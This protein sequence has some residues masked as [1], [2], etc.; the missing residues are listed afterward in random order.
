MPTKNRRDNTAVRETSEVHVYKYTGIQEY[1]LGEHGVKQ[2]DRG[3]CPT[4]K[5]T[6][7]GWQW[8]GTGAGPYLGRALMSAA[9][10]SSEAVKAVSP[11]WLMQ[12]S[13]AK[14]RLGASQVLA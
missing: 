7:T 5:K 8:A 9:T 12:T 1:M 3:S 2:G 6:S 13:T 10:T 4:E 11:P 14:S